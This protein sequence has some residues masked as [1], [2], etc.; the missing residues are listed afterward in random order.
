MQDDVRMAIDEVARQRGATTSDVRDEALPT[1]LGLAGE[2]QKTNARIAATLAS[3]LGA[4]TGAIEEG[5]MDVSWPGR[6]ERIGG[7]LLDAAHNPDGAVALA[8]HLRS[9]GVPPERV[10]LVFGALADKD[11]G[12]MLDR[13]APL[14][15][16]RV[17][18]A[19]HG[20]SRGGVEPAAMGARHPGRVCR[21][22]AE[23]LEAGKPGKAAAAPDRLTVVCG[24]MVL[25]GEA[26]AHLLGLPRDPPV[27]L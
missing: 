13:L 25:V 21:T 11:W 17:Y 18:V 3:R 27:A 2:H 22:A 4:S 26:R 6:L 19:L 24:S 20:A 5:L 10:T 1:H 9:L 16:D 7:V 14:A 8:T 23:A 15:G 12:G